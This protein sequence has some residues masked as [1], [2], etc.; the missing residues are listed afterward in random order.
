MRGI[1]WWVEG[2]LLG[3]GA[4]KSGTLISPSRRA[5]YFEHASR[6]QWS[7]LQWRDTRAGGWS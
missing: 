7:H 5:Y 3:G 1:E 6:S 2:E 4:A